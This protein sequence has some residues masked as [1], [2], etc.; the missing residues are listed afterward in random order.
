MG[1]L[2]GIDVGTTRTAAAVHRTD[3]PVDHVL[4]EMVT[5][6]DHSL[7]QPSVV[8]LLPD[9]SL[10]VGDAA[11]RRAMAEPDR[12]AREFK[13]RIGDPTPVTMGGR[14]FAAQELAAVLVRHVLDVVSRREGGPP[15]R[16]TVTHPASWGTHKL[17]LLTEALAAVLPMPVEFLAEPQAAAVCYA[18]AERVEPGSTIAVYDLGGGTFD[19]AVVRKD[20]PGSGTGG[21]TLLGRPEGLEFLGGVDFDE[22]VF[23]HV[24]AGAGDAFAGLDESDPAVW[25]AVARLRRECREAKEGLSSDTEVSVPVWLG[26]A[27]TVVRLHRSE[28]EELIGP[29]IEDSVEALRRAVDSA[30]L[31]PSELSSVLL[32]GGS[33]RIPLVAQ[34]V[35]ERLDRPVAV[36]ADPKN[37]IAKGAALAMLP[38]TGAPHP[39]RGIA[40]G[41]A[42]AVAGAAGLAGAGYGPGAAAGGAGSGPGSA[43]GG[44]GGTGGGV[45]AGAGH[46]H[47]AAGDVGP[48]GDGS[49]GAG[50]G[51][52]GGGVPAGASHGP[53][54]AGTGGPGGGVPAGATHG[55]VG[56]GTGGPG[57]GVP[58]GATHGP[59][60]A[61]GVGPAG[62]GPAGASTGGAGTDPAGTGAWPGPADTGESADAGAVGGAP[63]ADSPGPL[64]WETGDPVTTATPRQAEPPTN[65]IGP[66]EP[67]TAYLTSPG[68]PA[69]AAWTRDPET[70]VLPVVDG[71][72][73]YPHDGATTLSPAPGPDRGRSPAMLIGAG[74]VVAAIAVIGAL[75]FWPNEQSVSN[76]TPQLPAVPTAAPVPP[77]T[78]SAP[79]TETER[80]T[81]ERTVEQ[82]PD[83]SAPVPPP[84]VP[85][86]PPVPPTSAPPTT[87]QSQGPGPTTTTSAVPPPPGPQPR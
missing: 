61:G 20:A 78:E 1:Y 44:P 77:T 8:F 69:T 12:V 59:G 17:D 68:N 46:G 79:T 55:P 24:R 36:D 29:R 52:A 83:S 53:V 33:S 21:F 47:G 70:D 72:D 64:P 5:L 2:L 38:R 60:T 71:Y 13:R 26:G 43:D 14:A 84:V 28:F 19:S 10:L 56:A 34:T 54:G 50:A 6:G 3:T 82:E 86:I 42:A 37:A 58:A 87:T 45:P 18:A 4:P 74:G 39:G 75:V 51:G 31:D 15:E 22:V 35:S 80:R 57:G 7:D 81:R 66:A 73:R 25:A 85:T 67:A 32:V 27:Q 76:A 48:A 62:D 65:L 23:E 40:P 11:E 41:G 16:I 63:L 49:V 30:G 9:G